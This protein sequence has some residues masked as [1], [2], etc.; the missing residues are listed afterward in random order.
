MWCSH[1]QLYNICVSVDET[2][3]KADMCAAEMFCECFI[4]SLSLGLFHST[5]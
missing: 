2:G 1:A 4:S 3:S 5:H